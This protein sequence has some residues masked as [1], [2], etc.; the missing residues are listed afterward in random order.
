MDS[1]STTPGAFEGVSLKWASKKEIDIHVKITPNIVNIILSNKKNAKPFIPKS[2]ARFDKLCFI[3]SL[4]KG[5]SFC[6][7]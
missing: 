5:M 3:F 7:S 1:E 4:E 6:I 2:S